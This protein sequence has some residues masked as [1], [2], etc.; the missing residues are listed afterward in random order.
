[1]AKRQLS[2]LGIIM[3]V[4]LD[5]FGATIVA[6]DMGDLVSNVDVIAFGSVI[7]TKVVVHPKYG[8]QTKVDV[9][10]YDGLLGAKQRDIL[11]V[12]VP[13]GKLS[14]TIV[15]E[16]PG[17][18]VLKAGDRFFA[19]LERRGNHF[20]PWGLGF[21]WLKARQDPTNG[22]IRLF[23]ELDGL[24]VV[25]RSGE[26]IVPSRFA[27]RGVTLE[28][29]RERVKVYLQ[30]GNQVIEPSGTQGGVR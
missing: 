11:N 8:I 1:M 4:S 16:V 13:G 5:V 23:R 3:F 28:D 30:I 9:E 14:D 21:G 24:S 22:V 29:F 18:P 27:V 26:K 10:I 2:V 20:V 12:I 19:F 15:A 17:A 7:S 25:S 6:L